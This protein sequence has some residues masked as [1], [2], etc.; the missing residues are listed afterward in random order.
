MLREL[1]KLHIIN[2]LVMPPE[3]FQGIPDKVIHKYRMRAGTESIT[4]L[5]QHP[6]AIRY[7]LLAAFCH[8][9]RQEIVDGLVELLVQLLH[10]IKKNAE[11]KVI[12]FLVNDVKA[13]HGKNRLLYQIAE[14]ALDKPEDTVQNVLFPVVDKETLTALVKEY[15]AKG[16]FQ[17]Q[18]QVIIQNSYKQHYRR[19]LPKIMAALEFKSNNALHKPVIEALSYLR[20]IDDNQQRYISAK[21]VP[22]DA[23]VPEELRSLVIEEDKN[24]RKRIR[25]IPY[26]LTVL[27][28][29]RQRVRCKEVWVEGAKRY[30]N[31][32]EDVPQ[33]FAEKRT[34]YYKLLE[35]P[36]DPDLCDECKAHIMFWAFWIILALL[37]IEGN[38]ATSPDLAEYPEQVEAVRRKVEQKSSN[39]KK[40]NR[41][42]IE[43]RQVWHLITFDACLKKLGRSVEAT[44][45]GEPHETR[46]SWLQKALELD[47]DS[48]IYLDRHIAPASRTFRH[49]RFTRMQGKTIEVREYEKRIPVKVKELMSKITRVVA[50]AYE[51]ERD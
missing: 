19:M 37:M 43:E 29:L 40:K 3:L 18:V 34:D 10:K 41:K 39:P 7:T 13:V 21:D 27:Q 49:P 8:E 38:F 31:P 28:A 36:M 12:N 24:G 9:R 44:A 6:P 1:E 11:K 30:R 23:I 48:V 32:D 45:G 50:S 26:E 35:Q 20:T 47:P 17:K 25:R 22:V 42:Y 5:R 14:A 15:R 2:A 16:L 33:D 46:E 51:S 4:E